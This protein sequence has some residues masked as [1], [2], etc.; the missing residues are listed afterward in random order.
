MDLVKYAKGVKSLKKKDVYDTIALQKGMVNTIKNMLALNASND[1][2]YDQYAQRWALTKGILKDVGR[3][4]TNPTMTDVF[5]DSIKGI[6]FILSR[7]EQQAKGIDDTIDGTTLTIKETNILI[8]LDNIGF[9]TGYTLDLVEVLSSFA[10]EGKEDERGINKADLTFLNKTWSYYSDLSV[11]FMA[12]PDQIVRRLEK[13]SDV[14]ADQDSVDI[15]Q[16]A[17]GRDAV[18]AM[19]GFGI[20]TVLP[21]YWILDIKKNIDLGRIKAN[22]KRIEIHSMKLEQLMNK[23]NGSNDPHL[24]RQIEIYQNDIIKAKAKIEDI[25]ESYQV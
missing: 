9:W 1:V 13:L 24:D 11:Q 22:Q 25:V 12:E 23:R 6:E 21:V 15:V 14:P 19:R 8:I 7:L 10:L 20:H 3:R 17:K 18:N 5:V 16:N 4:V 2:G